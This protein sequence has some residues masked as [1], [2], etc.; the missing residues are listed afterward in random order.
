MRISRLVPAGLAALLVASASMGSAQAAPPDFL[1]DPEYRDLASAAI[2]T[3]G[4]TS[5][6]GGVVSTLSAEESSYSY[7]SKIEVGFN[8]ESQDFG[9]RLVQEFSEGVV[10]APQ[11]ADDSLVGNLPGLGGFLDKSGL[12]PSPHLSSNVDNDDSVTD[13]PMNKYEQWFGSNFRW[14]EFMKLDRNNPVERKALRLLGVPKATFAV[15]WPWEPYITGRQ[16]DTVMTMFN[17]ITP[18][19]VLASISGEAAGSSQPTTIGDVTA[20]AGDEGSTIYSVPLIDA[21]PS[22]NVV[23]VFTVNAD[24]VLMKVTYAF[25]DEDFSFSVEN[26]LVAWSKTDPVIAQPSPNATV[27]DRVELSAAVRYLYLEGDLKGAA[28]M[29]ANEANSIAAVANVK[30]SPVLIQRSAKN[31]LPQNSIARV[32]NIRKGV[33]LTLVDFPQG[34]KCRVT[35]EKKKGEWRAVNRCVTPK[36]FTPSQGVR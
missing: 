35:A 13:I 14:G 15:G 4:L 5:N 20:E 24:G 2:Y 34:I 1:S 22:G 27:V 30:V 18:A 10:V 33:M 7:T 16:A 26:E 8:N 19:S 25:D 9:A 21:V 23:F 36:N 3:S 31:L 6:W 17:V 32:T 11:R 12:L 29:V 28:R